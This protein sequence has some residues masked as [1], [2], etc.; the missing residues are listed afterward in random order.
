[1]TGN[2]L[3]LLCLADE[4]TTSQAF[5]VD[6]EPTMTVGHLKDLIKTKKTQFGNIEATMLTLWRV[7]IPSDNLSSPIK[8][9]TLG[10]KTCLNDP[11]TCL[12]TLFPQPPDGNTYILIQEPP[13]GNAKKNETVVS[14]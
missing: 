1:M 7:S 14:S 4:D 8:V 10:N 9:K 6:I 3:T 5:P 13:S 2:S 11:T 12:S